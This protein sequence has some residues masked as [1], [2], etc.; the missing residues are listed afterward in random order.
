MRIDYL[1]SC[2]RRHRILRVRR[3]RFH[4]HRQASWHSAAI[5]KR[6]QVKVPLLPRAATTAAPHVRAATTVAFIS[7]ATTAVADT[8]NTDADADVDADTANAD[9]AYDNRSGSGRPCR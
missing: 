3:R 7:S 9:D 5:E 6:P 2:Q 1:H 4:T 8:A